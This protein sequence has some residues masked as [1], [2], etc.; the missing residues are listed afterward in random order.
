LYPENEKNVIT[1]I[2]RSVAVC[3]LLLIFLAGSTGITFYIHTCGSSH[4]KEAFAFREIFN[5]KIPC[6]C[7]ENLASKVPAGSA[8][9]Y[10]DE[11]CCRISHLFIKAPF[12]G[13]PVVEKQSVPI[14]QFT[15]FPGFALLMSQPARDLNVSFTPFN[16]PSPP[17][18]SGINLVH[19]LHQI[20]IPAPVC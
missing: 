4:Q 20:R 18:L 17:P 5:Q 8:V 2:L 14:S 19:F 11:D 10:Q 12:L 9:N 1:R 7:D 13:Y 3:M 16:D 6:S 15:V